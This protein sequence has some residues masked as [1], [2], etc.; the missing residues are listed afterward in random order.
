MDRGE[1]VRSAFQNPRRSL[2][3]GKSDTIGNV[4]GSLEVASGRGN[5]VC[6][7][8]RDREAA[9][10]SGGCGRGCVSMKSSPWSDSRGTLE[11]RLYTSGRGAGLLYPPALITL[12]SIHEFSRPEH[13]RGVAFPFPRGSSQPKDRTHVSHIAGGFFT[14]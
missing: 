9:K 4:L 2:S 1:A 14:S 7:A 11:H 3:H 10:G 6:V 5:C 13:W 12:A 8:Y